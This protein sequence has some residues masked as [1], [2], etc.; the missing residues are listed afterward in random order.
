M[1]FSVGWL[2]G[3]K[4]RKDVRFKQA[5]GEKLSAD[6]DAA[7]NWIKTEWPK[8]RQEYEPSQI[9]NTD[10]T[11]LYYRGLPNKSMVQGNAK[12]SGGKLPK[13]RISVLV[14]CSM[15]GVRKRLLVIG[16]SQKP[17]GFP[18][19]RETLPVDYRNSKKAWMNSTIW[20]EY[21]RKWDRELRFKNRKILLLADNAPSHPK[22]S[23]L[24]HIRLE[25]LPKNTTSLIQ[26]CFLKFGT[27]VHEN[28][29]PYRCEICC[30][31]FSKKTFLSSHLCLECFCSKPQKAHLCSHVM[32]VSSSV[33]RDSIEVL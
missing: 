5:E 1:Q 31:E 4:N 29:K 3:F 2:D 30:A 13:N 18:S 16:L 27:E 17:R 20:I 33:S 11:G 25:F 15:T 21:L 6:F 19:D 7:E 12:V 14:T 22:V 10:E 24:T 23:G 32:Q 8:L 9:Y 26:V 28:K